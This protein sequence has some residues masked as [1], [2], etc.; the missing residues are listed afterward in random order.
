MADDNLEELIP[1]SFYTS[2]TVADAELLA[3]INDQNDLE[4][5]I[6]ARKGWITKALHRVEADKVWFDKTKLKGKQPDTKGHTI[7]RCPIK[8]QDSQD[9]SSES[10]DGHKSPRK[11]NKSTSH[12]QVMTQDVNSESKVDI[13]DVGTANRFVSYLGAS[14]LNPYH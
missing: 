8:G 12:V 14:D 11:N 10:D 7:S 6:T 9:S 5:R 2:K 4:R 13:D 1:W 3:K